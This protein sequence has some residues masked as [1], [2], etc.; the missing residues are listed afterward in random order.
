MLL[1]I[2]E[3]DIRSSFRAIAAW[4]RRHLAI[5]GPLGTIRITDRDTIVERHK[6][7]V[8]IPFKRRISRPCMLH[9]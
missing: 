9:A 5:D 3:Y 4:E 1:G 7:G 8:G 2:Q 6:E